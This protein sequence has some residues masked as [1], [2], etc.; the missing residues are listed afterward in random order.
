MCPLRA[1]GGYQ[2]L[3]C[4]LQMKDMQLLGPDSSKTLY[5]TAPVAA[6]LVSWQDES[7]V[8]SYDLDCV[9]SIT[10]MPR[11]RLPTLLILFNE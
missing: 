6:P 3:V 9:G 7:S 1:Y 11:R 8:Q 5:L 4:H 10:A 2:T